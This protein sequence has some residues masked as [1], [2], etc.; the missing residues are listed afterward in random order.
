MSF[1]VGSSQQWLTEEALLQAKN[2]RDQPGIHNVLSGSTTRRSG[3]LAGSTLS[4]GYDWD[5]RV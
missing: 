1:V 3:H 5:G 4:V 2:D